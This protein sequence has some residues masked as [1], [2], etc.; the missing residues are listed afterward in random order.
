MGLLKEKQ[1]MSYELILIFIWN[2]TYETKSIW[3]LKLKSFY[4]K[5]AYTLWETFLVSISLLKSYI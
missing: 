3:H 5:E 4:P 1:N 2:E